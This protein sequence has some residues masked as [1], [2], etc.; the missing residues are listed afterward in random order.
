M[1]RKQDIFERAAEWRLR[2]DVVEKDYVLGWL[3]S[4]LA[5]HPVCR[6]SWVF[7]GGTCIKKCYFETYRFS[8]DLDFSLLPSAPY[9]AEEIRQ[10]LLSVTRTASELSGVLFP[11][12]LVEVQ[13]C[14][15][16]QRQ[17]AF[18]GKV[19]YIGPLRQPQTPTPPR[20]LFD[21]TRHEPVLDQP[22]QRPV[23]HPYPDILPDG[24][25][26]TACSINELLA[27]KARALYERTRPRDLLRRD[28]HPRQPPGPSA[29]RT[30]P[31]PV[32]KEV[33]RQGSSDSQC[34]G[35]RADSRA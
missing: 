34:G 16:K 10:V 7:K 1:I 20:V 11:E 3:L 13:Q 19:S 9:T 24:P 12:H 14:Y 25:P 17:P 30:G 21:I 29:P 2:P 26:V 28:L 32:P 4:A 23:F 35:T 33:Q 8:E 15:N 22:V 31:R 5:Q 18:Q 6:D 27:E